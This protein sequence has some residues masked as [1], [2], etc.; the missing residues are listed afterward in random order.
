MSKSKAKGT[1]AESAIAN[2][3]RANGFPHVERRALSGVND[4]GDI[5]GIPGVVIEIKNVATMKLAEWVDETEV[6]RG[7]ADA[8][9]AACWHKRKG[10]GDPLDWYVTMTGAQFVALLLERES[11]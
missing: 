9:V 4:K 8:D 7:N 6:E 5:T 1:Q 10:K 11:C 3:L 2:T